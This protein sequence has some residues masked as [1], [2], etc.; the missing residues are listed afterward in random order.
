[1]YAIILH[2][3][4]H[5]QNRENGGLHTSPYLSTLEAWRHF[6][7]VGFQGF[8]SFEL[9]LHIPLFTLI[10]P[11][12]WIPS[13]DMLPPESYPK[14]DGLPRSVF[15]VA[16]LSALFMLKPPGPG[17]WLQ[18]VEKEGKGVCASY[19][20]TPHNPCMQVVL[21]NA[22]STTCLHSCSPHFYIRD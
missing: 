17:T 18:E 16:V 1:M 7:S 19:R 11:C 3:G 15:I 12:W 6:E 20:T 9:N 22:S 14:R 13:T 5:V 2:R 21:W 4:Q 8:R 10:I